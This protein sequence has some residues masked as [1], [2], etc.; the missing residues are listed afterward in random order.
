MSRRRAY[1]GDDRASAFSTSKARSGG[2]CLKG[3]RMEVNAPGGLPG[4]K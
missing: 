4:K 2:V 3:T 1:E